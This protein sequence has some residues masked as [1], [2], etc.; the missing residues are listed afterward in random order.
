MRNIK[1]ISKADVTTMI[2][3]L[4]SSLE[5]IKEMASDTSTLYECYKTVGYAK[6]TIETVIKQLKG[7]YPIF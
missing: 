4:E 2:A 5:R 1:S 6:G 3:T 7:E